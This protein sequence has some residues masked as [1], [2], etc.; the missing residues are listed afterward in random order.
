MTLD[1]G[2][3]RRGLSRQQ[4]LVFAA[5]GVAAAAFPLWLFGGDYLKD[6]SEAM[7]LVRE[8][9]IDG[10]PCRQVT[11]AQFAAEGRRLREGALYQDVTFVRQFGHMSCASLRYGGG[12][13]PSVYPVCQFT[14]PHGVKV[15]TD[16]G[17][18][19]YVVEPGQPA[20]VATPHGQ[21]RCVLHANFSMKI[22][23]TGS[24][25]AQ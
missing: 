5:A 24:R 12:W 14:S 8:W 18:W 9:Q 19:F 1:L 7:S 22:L 20:T 16:K 13:S 17:E 6:R 4:K 11:A 23:K 2:A 15:V 21:A 3:R 25:P 10:P